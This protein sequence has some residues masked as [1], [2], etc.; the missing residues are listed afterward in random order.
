[1]V[2]CKKYDKDVLMSFL[3]L[4]EHVYKEYKQIRLCVESWVVEEIDN[5]IKVTECPKGEKGIAWPNNVKPSI[6]RNKDEKER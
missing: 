4:F 3:L 2:Y 5:N 1:M 6:F